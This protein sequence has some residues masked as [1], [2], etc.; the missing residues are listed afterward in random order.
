LEEELSE[1]GKFNKNFGHPKN[2]SLE[3][4]SVGLKKQIHVCT[5]QCE[6]GEN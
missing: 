1:K 6:F 4:T 3:K 2:V 5:Q